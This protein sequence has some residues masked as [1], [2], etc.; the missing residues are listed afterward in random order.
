MSRKLVLL[1]G[2]GLS[3]CSISIIALFINCQLHN[4]PP[5]VPIYPN[6]TLIEES[7]VGTDALPLHIYKYTAQTSAKE[8][9]QFY[10]DKGRCGVANNG[11][12]KDVEICLG[13]ATP[14]GEYFVYVNLDPEESEGF[15]DYTLEIRWR[16]CTLKLV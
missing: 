13:K 2:I 3:V 1:I 5:D 7:S 10:E 14:F 8:I 4:S 16:A 9:I 12:K 11:H 15:T 6:S